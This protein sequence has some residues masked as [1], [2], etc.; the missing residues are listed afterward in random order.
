[1]ITKYAGRL[2]GLSL[3][4]VIAAGGVAMA[5]VKFGAV[6]PFSGPL[7]LLGDESFRGLELAVE[8]INAKGG[9]QG[10]KIVLLRGDAVDN[11]QA[12]GE[13][14]RLISRERVGAIFGSYS[15]ARSIAASQVSELE[16]IPYFELGAAADEVTTRGFKYL[17]RTNPT[18]KDLAQTTIDLVR[19]VVLP[20]SGIAAGDLKL[21]IV[22]EDTSYGTA[23]ARH[24][25]AMAAAEGYGV[26]ATHPYPATTVDMSPI[27]LDLQRR[28]VNVVLQTGY[29]NDSVLLIRQIKEG[30]FKPLSIIG[31]GAGYGLQATADTVGHEQIEGVLT[32]D[33]TQYVINPDYAPGIRDFEAAYQTKYGIFPRSG[34]SL[35]SYVGAKAILEAI[36]KAP[37]LKPDTLLSSVGAI[38][39]PLGETAAGYGIKF[40]AQHQNERTRTMGLQWQNGRLV[41]IYPAEAAAAQYAPLK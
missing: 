20:E 21:G 23:L 27:V 7:A 38:D 10:E 24:Q 1:M 30:G 19:D 5:D 32:S 29:Q 2:V 22:H 40:D 14:R 28:G 17:Y 37:D 16:Q 15:S 35:S 18:V 31:G 4:A 3:A 11:N 33:F 34:H 36:D 9:V 25:A 39:I 13:A 41:T 26:V 8:E 12:I 6:F